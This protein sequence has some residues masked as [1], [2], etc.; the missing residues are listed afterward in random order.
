[1]L[2]VPR[3][4]VVGPNNCG[5]VEEG[6]T[7]PLRPALRS[8]AFGEDRPGLASEAPR[9]LQ[10]GGRGVHDPA[11]ASAT[12]YGLRPQ[13]VLRGTV[14]PSSRWHGWG[15]RT[16]LRAKG[17]WRDECAHH[18]PVA[19]SAWAWAERSFPPSPHRLSA[20]RRPCPVLPSRRAGERRLVLRTGGPRES[21]ASPWAMTVS[22]A[23]QAVPQ[24]MEERDRWSSV[25]Q[26]AAEGGGAKRWPE[27]D[28]RFLSLPPARKGVATPAQG[29]PLQRRTIDSSPFHPQ[30]KGAADCPPRAATPFR[31]PF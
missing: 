23:R 31:S 2:V 9:F 5:R 8:T 15:P 3:P 16:A 14:N 26:S 6:F 11:P 28:H 17:A 30:Q 27:E 7:V 24:L 13:I 20:W 22:G 21:R 19:L 4:G 1:M 12:L 18:P 25:G 10:E 29:P